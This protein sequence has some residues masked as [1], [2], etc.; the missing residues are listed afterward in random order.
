MRELRQTGLLAGLD[1]TA[2]PVTSMVLRCRGD[3]AASHWQ[4][5]GVLFRKWPDQLQQFEDEV[6]GPMIWSDDGEAWEYER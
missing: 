1:H 6:L 4:S 2:G 3:C 5:E